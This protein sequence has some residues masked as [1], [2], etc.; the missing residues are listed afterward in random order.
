MNETEYT[1]GSLRGTLTLAFCLVLPPIGLFVMWQKGVF[2]QLGRIILTVLGC[3]EMFVFILTDPFGWFFTT[4]EPV[5]VQPA[6]AA[7]KVVSY[8]PDDNALNALYNIDE[9]IAANTTIEKTTGGTTE[10]ITQQ[11]LNAMNEEV[12]NT[13][14]YSVWRNASYYHKGTVCGNQSNGRSLTVRE[15]IEEGLGACPECNPPTPQM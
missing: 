5:Q 9:I 13:V 10:Y 15:A 2:Q 7:A 3:I 4:S 1:V 12:Y 6:P 14:V 11:E 8:A